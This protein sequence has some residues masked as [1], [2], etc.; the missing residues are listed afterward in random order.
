MPFMISIY[1]LPDY[2]RSFTS[3][4]AAAFSVQSTQCVIL[5]VV[6]F[7]SLW[8]VSG[9]SQSNLYLHHI[10]FWGFKGAFNSAV[11]EPLQNRLHP[12]AALV[13]KGR[14]D[15]RMIANRRQTGKASRRHAVYKKA[16]FS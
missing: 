5:I 4:W 10:V 9:W 12:N 8:M 11:A 1:L 6:A 15:F 7:D 2:V 14:Q 3:R 13:E 16:T